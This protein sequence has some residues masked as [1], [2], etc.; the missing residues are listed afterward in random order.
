MKNLDK[1]KKNNKNSEYE[2]T[3]FKTLL[4]ENRKFK[5]II[6]SAFTILGILIVLNEVLDLPHI[7]FGVAPTPINWVE[8]VLE[9]II[10]FIVG[11]IALFIL[12]S[13]ESKRK[14][15]KDA[16]SQSEEKYFSLIT[17]SNEGLAIHKMIYNDCGEYIDY[18]ITD[19]NPAYEKITG[20]KK[21]G[22]IGKLA[23]EV[24]E[25]E[26]APYIDIF[27]KVADT[28]ES[29]TFEPTFDQIGIAL[30]VSVFS[31][32]KREFVTLFS[33]ITERKK[34][35]DALQQNKNRLLKAQNVAGMGFLDWN[36]KT[37]EIEL[38]ENTINI[39]GLDQDHNWITPE[40]VTKIVHADDLEL[41]QKNLELAVTGKRDYNID[42]RIVRPDGIVIWTHSQAELIK[43]KDGNPVSLLGTMIDIT[44]RKQ[45]EDE[46]NETTRLLESVMDA[47]TDEAI[48]T[49]DQM[50]IILNWN[51]GAR[52]LLGYESEEVVGRKSIRTFQT[53][54]WQK[55]GIMDV[56]IKK[57]IA[58]GKPL[59][60]ENDHITKDGKMIPVQTIVS[61]RFDE[62][63]KFIGMLGMVRDITISKQAELELQQSKERFKH[64]FEN[65]GD[66]VFVTK[67]G[68][69]NRGQILET[70]S[71]ASEQTGYTKK[72]LLQMNI[73]RDL[74]ITGSGEINTDDWDELLFKG[75][76]VTTTE[77]KRKKDGT[78]SW[79]EVIVTPIEFKG[80][81]ASL[82][83]NHDITE[84]KQ[85]EEA[86]QQYAQQLQE[87]NEDLDAFSHTVAHDL[88]NPLGTIMGFADLLL[89][90]YSK[91]SKDEI[92]NYLSL[93][94]ND[95]KKTQQIINSL[96]LFASVRK[97]E[98]KTEELNMGDIVAETIDRLTSM[99]KKSDTEIILPD[100]WPVALG[101]APWIE[102]VWTN[103]LSNAIKYGG[104]T[105]YIEI[106]TDTGNMENVPE[107]M[108]RFWIRDNGPGISAENKKLLFNKF[109]RLDQVKTEGHGLGLSIVRRIIGKLG[110]EVGVESEQG[111]GSLFYFTLP[112]VFNTHTETSNTKPKN[113]LSSESALGGEGEKPE[114]RNL[115]ILIAEDVESADLHLSIVLKK[116][117]RE[118]LHAKTGKDTV[119]ICQNNPDI[120]LVL[121]DI[122][123]PEMNGYEATRKIREFNKDVVIIAQTAYAIRGDRE[124]AIEAG[125]DDYISKP[126]KREM[127]MAM[128]ERF[129]RDS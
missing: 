88:K 127:L 31:Y 46:L 103:Y 60:I 12:H 125:C 57:M 41:V 16:L 21:E 35:E 128:I 108:V 69:A 80:E 85:A 107:G 9:V 22:V 97:V 89:E 40:L 100:V 98:I 67:I 45:A 61:P 54:E 52:R 17:S 106:G 5:L 72:E 1:L 38:S 28:G 74:Y 111:M 34:V 58:T 25:T 95:G 39:F 65:L 77:K 53:E 105:P 59:T 47:A 51:E 4:K 75:E 96:L 82:S 86:M 66:A 29:I 26:T 6:I 3:H 93:I 56:N 43:D 104:T 119:K 64:L 18:K 114:T 110:G 13:I 115:K 48:I 23:T 20:L 73:I 116:I 92:S 109:E 121:M 50:G 8:Y 27:G 30:K 63:G 10:T 36:L 71:A 70:N 101:Y 2:N 94:I 81:K 120:D 37:D 124:K 11:S 32:K 113:F 19:V 83:I 44:K 102:E 87:H 42:H 91:L 99:I 55:S 24:Y 33:D 126:I 117:S 123:M 118:I 14:K 15:V 90:G 49:T 62:D 112:F 79:T 76:T 78:E 68:G 129:F 7:I 84:R 122:Q